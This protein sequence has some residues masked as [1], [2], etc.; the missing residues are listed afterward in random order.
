MLT[1][2]NN[3]IRHFLELLQ[4][5]NLVL[6]NLLE[7]EEKKRQVII[8]G[9]VE[10]LNKII[11][12]EGMLVSDLE[13]LE[14]ARFKSQTKLAEIWE[15]PVEELSADK[16]ILNV[17]QNLPEIEAELQSAVKQ[18]AEQLDRLKASNNENND[19]INLSLEYIHTMQ[20]MLNGEVAGTYTNTGVQV[21]ETTVR[22]ALRLLDKKA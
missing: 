15:I 10:E 9:Q 20:S 21:D 14:D 5:Q 8:L 16:I 2:L 17:N 1:N 11:P 6:E 19:L 12:K 3:E 7:L 4:K 13:K 18:I 22:P